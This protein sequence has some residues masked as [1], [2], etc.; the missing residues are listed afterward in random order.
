[1]I[2]ES[3]IQRFKAG[4]LINVVVQDNSTK[5]VLM[6]AWANQEALEKSI[7]SGNATFWSRSRNRIWIKGEESGNYQ[8]IINIKL[9]CDGDSLLYLVDPA[10]PACHNGTI[11]CFEEKI[12]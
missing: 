11:T 5:D 1:M 4:E 3:L 7:K 12:L 2:P 8:R 9:D 6:V 10:G